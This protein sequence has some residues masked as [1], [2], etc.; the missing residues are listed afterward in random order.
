MPYIKV[1][2]TAGV[3]VEVDKHYSARYGRRSIRSPNWRNTPENQC[4]VNERRAEDN[5]RRIINTNFGVGDIHM[6][7]GYS[8]KFHPTLAEARRDKERFTRKY[9]EWCHRQGINRAIL[10]LPS[11]K[12]TVYT[13]IL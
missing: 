8:R 11:T 10:P 2:Y 4:K 7:L 6:T 1:T 12:D 13:T 9:R 5:L 3:T